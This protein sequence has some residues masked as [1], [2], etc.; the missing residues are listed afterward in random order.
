MKYSNFILL[1]LLLLL[2]LLCCL[3]AGRRT[4]GRYLCSINKLSSP[5]FSIFSFLLQFPISSPVSQIIQELCSSSCCFHFHHLS[6]NGIMKEA[7]SPQNMTNGFSTQDIYKCPLLSYKVK[8]LFISYFL[9]PFYLFHFPPAPHFK[10][11]QILPLS[12]LDQS[13]YLNILLGILSHSG[14]I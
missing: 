11:L 5:S 13:F 4:Y 3:L 6:F 8:N 14:P 1:L 10:T 12:S 2:L 7:F 9:W